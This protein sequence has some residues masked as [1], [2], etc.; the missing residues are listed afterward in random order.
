MISKSRQIILPNGEEK[1]KDK[2][3]FRY[4]MNKFM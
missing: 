1:G 4:E 2:S 3:G